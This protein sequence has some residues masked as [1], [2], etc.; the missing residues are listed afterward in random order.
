VSAQAAATLRQQGAP[1]L[2]VRY[3]EHV[4][5]LSIGPDAK[6]IR[7]NAAKALLTLRPDLD[8][9][10]TRPTPARLADLRRSGGWLFV[11]WCFLEGHLRPD[12]DLLI[13]K[14]PGDLYTA[15]I[16]RHHDVVTRVAEVA[17]RFGW[18]ANWIEHL[19][20]G[21]AMICLW[22]AKELG[23]LD[24]VDFERFLTELASSPS[25][26]HDARSHNSARAFSLHQVCYE[27]GIC[28]CPPR[29]NMRHVGHARR[30]G[31]CDPSARHPAGGAALPGSRP[32]HA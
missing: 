22:A 26:H 21:M 18:S 12:M 13:A 9:W 28:D 15:W 32:H 31:R 16:E 4:Q 2:L 17:A 11:C 20:A 23:E 5:G 29:K 6:R 8:A 7:R 14:A 25:A 19:N 10:M 1:D 24:G 27:L 3:A 30:I